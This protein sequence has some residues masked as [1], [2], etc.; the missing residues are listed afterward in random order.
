[1]AQFDEST[2]MK[3]VACVGAG[4]M[5]HS[6][7]ALFAVK[8]HLVWLHD[9]SE[10]S[11]DRALRWIE[12]ALGL[13]SEKG[14]IR[15]RAADA[16]LGRVKPTTDLAEAVS[17]AGFVME[18]V[19]ESYDVKKQVFREMDEAAPEE[20]IL[21][22]GSSGLLMTEIQ[23]ATGSPG[24]CIG[25]H[26]FNPPHLIPLVELVP[27]EATSE[28]TVERTFRLMEGLGKVPIVVKKEVAWYLGNRMQNSVFQAAYDIVDSGIASVE[29]VDLAMSTG[30]GIRWALYGPFLVSY[31]NTPSH[32]GR[33]RRTSGLVTKGYEEYSLLKGRSFDDMV[34]WRNSRL[35]DI[36]HILGHLPGSDAR[37]T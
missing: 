24:R 34:R 14:L 35:I 32:L 29:D 36:L 12:E 2:G 18:S 30:L 31:F 15:E 37:G 17:H 20:T 9:I 7:A 22:S 28:Q 11:L 6:W 3:E 4:V 23:K 21:A 13:F 26:G 10:E 16:A 25:A 1:M 33:R 8:G 5:G 27:G 19:T